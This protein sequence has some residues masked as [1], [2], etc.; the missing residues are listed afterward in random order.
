MGCTVGGRGGGGPAQLSHLH[1]SPSESPATCRRPQADLLHRG[2]A[3]WQVLGAHH[4]ASSRTEG[5]AAGD[6]LGLVVRHLVGRFCGKVARDKG[7]RRVEGEAIY[8]QAPIQSCQVRKV[9]ASPAKHFGHCSCS[10]CRTPLLGPQTTASSGRIVSWGELQMYCFLKTTT[11][12][13]FFLNLYSEHVFC[14][15]GSPVGLG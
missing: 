5:T 14:K 4:L 2:E 6:L 7:A 10:A 12:M 3:A 8:L 13:Y 11:N 15:H 9:P 1:A